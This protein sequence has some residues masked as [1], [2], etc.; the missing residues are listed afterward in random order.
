MKSS[1]LLFEPHFPALKLRRRFVWVSVEP[2]EHAVS[3]DEV[4]KMFDKIFQHR[5]VQYLKNS[6]HCKP[7]H[8]TITLKSYVF[9]PIITSLHKHQVVTCE[10]CVMHLR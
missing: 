10:Y 1:A 5:C 2:L 7:G 6:S 8:S 9:L 4:I 3:V